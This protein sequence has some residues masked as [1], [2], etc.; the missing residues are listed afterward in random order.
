MCCSVG[1]CDACTEKKNPDAVLMQVAA[2]QHCKA[3]ACTPAEN[4]QRLRLSLSLQLPAFGFSP[5]GLLFIRL[6]LGV[7]GGS[8]VSGYW[9][10][11]DRWI[12]LVLH[13]NQAA[14]MRDPAQHLGIP[15]GRICDAC[16]QHGSDKCHEGS[17]G[18]HHR[19]AVMRAMTSSCHSDKI[20]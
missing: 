3:I 18:A 15:S 17:N 10:Q 1:N 5:F 20:L 4:D 9:G 11:H 6:T 19:V 12:H 14:P 13:Y 8:G 7:G 2:W 16:N